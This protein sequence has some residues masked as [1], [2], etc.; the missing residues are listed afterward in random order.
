MVKKSGIIAVLVVLIGVMIT[1]C[2]KHDNDYKQWFSDNIMTFTVGDRIP[3]TV[4]V[5]DYILPDGAASVTSIQGQSDN[6]AVAAVDEKGYITGLS[7]GVSNITC[8][9]KNERKRGV[10]T[11]FFVENK[12]ITGNYKGALCT[13]AGD[14]IDADCSMEIRKISED[15]VDYG[16]S[17]YQLFANFE[18]E[19]ELID[20]DCNL[21]SIYKENPKYGFLGMASN[22]TERIQVAGSIDPDNASLFVF[23]ILHSSLVFSFE[24]VLTPNP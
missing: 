17:Q 7:E 24:G 5:N 22:P 14:S 15:G 3:L 9:T 19:G 6:E 20:I 23:I 11:M 18:Y 2:H 13:Q 10:V 4:L 12:G 21:F 1:S 8:T 16:F